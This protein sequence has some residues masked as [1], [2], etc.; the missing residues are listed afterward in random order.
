[1]T[2]GRIVSQR[3]PDVTFATFGLERLGNRNAINREMVNGQFI[4]DVQHHAG[5][6]GERSPFEVSHAVSTYDTRGLASERHHSVP[7]CL[8]YFRRTNQE[9]A[10]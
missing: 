4:F 7:S 9:R 10:D 1:V 2:H 3:N 6:I 8:G 5:I